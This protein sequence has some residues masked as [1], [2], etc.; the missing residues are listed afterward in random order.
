MSPGD[1]IVLDIVLSIVP[2]LGDLLAD[3]IIHGRIRRYPR[4]RT[5]EL[6]TLFHTSRRCRFYQG[7]FLSQIYPIDSGPL[8]NFPFNLSSR[9][10]TGRPW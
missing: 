3:D 4:M 8:H 7:I 10:S 6:V 9:D 1:L 5:L 2:R